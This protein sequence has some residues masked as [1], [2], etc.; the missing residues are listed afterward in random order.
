VAFVTGNLDPVSDRRAF[1]ALFNPPPV[2]ILVLCGNATPPRSKSEM[3]ALAGQSGIDLRWLPG[4]LGLHEECAEAIA[5]PIIRFF[6]NPRSLR[7]G[8]SGV[9]P[10]DRR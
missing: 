7:R 6:R 2:P 1:L 4:A 5:D 10:R 8:D 3:A 9:P